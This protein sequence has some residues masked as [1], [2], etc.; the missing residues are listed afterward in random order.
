MTTMNISQ[1]RQRFLEI[2]N[3]VYAGEEFVVTK[4][5]IPVLTISPIRKEKKIKK[6][7][8]RKIDP[9]VFGMWKNRWPK[10]KS[11]VDVVN[12]WRRQEEMRSYD[13]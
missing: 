6:I 9:K 13:R 3:R 12:E 11:S 4:N 7:F 2:A 5:K 10:S 8:K 1:A